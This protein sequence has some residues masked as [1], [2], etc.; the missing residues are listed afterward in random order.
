[1]HRTGHAQFSFSP[2]RYTIIL[3]SLAAVVLALSVAAV[4]SGGVVLTPRQ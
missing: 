3:I 1:M 2:M 4:V